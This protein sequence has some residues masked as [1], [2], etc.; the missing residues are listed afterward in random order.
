MAFI[1]LEL[2]LGLDLAPVDNEQVR[3]EEQTEKLVQITARWFKEIRSCNG[4]MYGEECGA[5]KTCCWS[6][7]ILQLALIDLWCVEE[8]PGNFRLV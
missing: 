1:A 8:V 4:D 6:A 2:L 7:P 5:Y 3:W